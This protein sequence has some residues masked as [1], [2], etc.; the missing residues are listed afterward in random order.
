MSHNRCPYCGAHASQLTA[1][2]ITTI[3]H[4][5]GMTR[6]LGDSH[7]KDVDKYYLRCGNCDEIF[8]GHMDVDSEAEAIK[9]YANCDH[10]TRCNDVSMGTRPSDHLDSMMVHVE[11]DEC[12]RRLDLAYADVKRD[13]TPKIA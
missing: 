10:E 12:K 3:Y 2:M 4:P 1:E 13:G 9:T 6:T 8:T 11:C 7:P 5:P